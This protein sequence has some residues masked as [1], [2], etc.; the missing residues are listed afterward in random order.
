M[1]FAS[2]LLVRVY[3]PG[4]LSSHAGLGHVPHVEMGRFKTLGDTREPVCI[5]FSQYAIFIGHRIS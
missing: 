1:V 3:L 5:F 4:V 2:I